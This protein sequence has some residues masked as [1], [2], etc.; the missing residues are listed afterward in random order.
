VKDYQVNQF[1]HQAIVKFD[2]EKTNV[3]AIGKALTDEGFPPEGKPE[4]AN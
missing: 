2:D 3:D 4:L 1:T